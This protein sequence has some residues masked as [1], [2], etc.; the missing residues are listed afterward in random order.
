MADPEMAVEDADSSR[1]L[2]LEVLAGNASGSRIVVEEELVIGRHARGIGGLADDIELSRQ[3]A[4]ISREP[5]GGYVIEDM[6]STNGTFVNALQIESPSPLGLGDT[7]EV[8]ATSLLIKSLPPTSTGLTG[9]R[10]AARSVVTADAPEM[11]AALDL[12]LEV[13][14]DKREATLSLQPGQSFRLVLVDG[15]WRLEEE[16]E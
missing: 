11:Q 5:G 9:Q 7:I 1:A 15:R 16:E 2:I 3:H 4:R 13:D 8:G 6:G 12:R 10:T 14:F